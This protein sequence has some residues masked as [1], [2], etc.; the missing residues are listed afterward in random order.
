MRATLVVVVVEVVEVATGVAVEIVG[1]RVAE[2]YLTLLCVRFVRGIIS[3][4]N[5]R[6]WCAIGARK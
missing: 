3:P 5:A 4:Q 2:M 1:V 6:V